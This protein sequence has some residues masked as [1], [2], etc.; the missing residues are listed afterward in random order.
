[1]LNSLF[2]LNDAFMYKSFYRDLFTELGFSEVEIIEGDDI[3]VPDTMVENT[4]FEDYGEEPP[5]E[6]QRDKLYSAYV[7]VTV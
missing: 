2:R 7:R 5:L 6:E 4:L 1:M 3:G